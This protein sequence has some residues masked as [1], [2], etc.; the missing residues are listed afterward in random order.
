MNV[1]R[2]MSTTAGGV[3]VLGTLVAVWLSGGTSLGQSESRPTPTA[4][5]ES[6]VD[7]SD[8]AARTAKAPVRWDASP[9]ADLAGYVVSWGDAPGRYTSTKEVGPDVTSLELIVSLR[10]NPYFVVVQARDKSGKLS[11]YSNEFGLDVSSG[12]ARPLRRPKTTAKSTRPAAV[13][14]GA[15]ASRTVK[16]KLTKEEKAQLRREKQERR[17][18]KAQAPPLP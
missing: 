12:V 18:K 6:A 3:A 7:S 17:A 5:V 4:P 13:S 1:T 10:P 11:G 14:S 15:D 16:P 8:A 2:Q 9:E